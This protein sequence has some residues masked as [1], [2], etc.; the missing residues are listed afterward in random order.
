MSSAMPRS[1]TERPS[2]ASPR[3]SS[4]PAA[5]SPQ[6]PGRVVDLRNYAPAYLSWIANKLSRG[7]SHAYLAAFD[8]GI[9]TWRVLVL[10]AIEPAL[11]AQRVSKVIGMD[12]GQV[13]R[14]FKSMHAKGLIR[15]GLD[16]DDGR[17]RMASITPAGRALHDR[18]L[19]LALERERALLSP[20][21]E[22]ERELLLEL[23]RKVH[24][25]LPLAEEATQR[26]LRERYPQALRRASAGDAEEP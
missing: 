2:R 10:L 12:K 3:R 26:F 13:S 5:A 11:S 14:T 9:E 20:L 15:I 4:P 1:A 24:E 21:S 23:L 17:L 8:V 19:E 7:A 22:A 18:I 6:A 16:A 25:S